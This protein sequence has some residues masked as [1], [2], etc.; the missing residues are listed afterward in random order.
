MKCFTGTDE[1][2]YSDCSEK[3]C[4]P[5]D[6]SFTLDN[7]KLYYSPK[8]KNGIPL[9][10]YTSVGKQ[11]NPTRIAAFGLANFNR[12]AKT[13]DTSAQTRFH[14]CANWFLQTIDGKYEYDF[15]WKDLSPPWISCMSQGEA[16][17]ILVRGYLDSNHK[18][19]LDHAELSLEPFFLSIEEGGVASRLSDGS[20]FLEEYP[21]T[22]P[23]HVLNGFLYA[24]IGL[25]EFAKVSGSK[26][27]FDLYETLVDSIHENISIWS[28]GKWSLYEDPRGSGMTN[29]CTPSYHNLQISQL[30]WLNKRTPSENIEKT[31]S[32]WVKGSNSLIMR[33]RALGQKSAFRLIHKAQR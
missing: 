32:H 7:E 13:R 3:W 25:Y 29:W 9:K 8:D 26:R 22:N 20:L 11:Y 24:L 31:I 17:S 19:Y 16:A 14:D 28:S 5:I 21:S 10:V 23:P 12:F 6:L 4:Y 18:N 27:H 33:L 30:I 2:A 15:N 1:F